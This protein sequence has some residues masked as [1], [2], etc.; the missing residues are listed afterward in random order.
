MYEK[1]HIKPWSKEIKWRRLSWTGHLLWLPA[2]TPARQR[3]TESQ[4]SVKRPRGKLK[5]SW[6]CLITSELSRVGID[7]NDTKKA[8]EKA[9]DRYAWKT[10]VG[11]VMS[12]DE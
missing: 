1:K 9:Q 2:E 12:H 5:L 8:T 4:R 10:L 7:L 11:H 6:L 3:L